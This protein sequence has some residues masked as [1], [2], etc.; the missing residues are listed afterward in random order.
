MSS[1]RSFGTGDNATTTNFLLVEGWHA[2]NEGSNE[3]NALVKRQ[4]LWREYGPPDCYWGM[5]QFHGPPHVLW[6]IEDK[7]CYGS[8]RWCK[9]RV[10]ARSVITSSAGRPSSLT[11]LMVIPVVLLVMTSFSPLLTAFRWSDE[12]MEDIAFLILASLMTT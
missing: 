4:D 1:E 12:G 11:V 7:I 2:D 8:E 10:A 3:T 9:D 5:G 6:C